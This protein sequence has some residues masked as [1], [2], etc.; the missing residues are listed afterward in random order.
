M[1]AELL[2]TLEKFPTLKEKITFLFNDS[3]EFQALCH[4]YFLCMKSLGQW[5]MSV[6]KDEKFLREYRQLKT[7]LESELLQYVD[8]LGQKT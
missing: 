5:E 1:K 3:E 7:T 2:C 4:D 8:H 6:E